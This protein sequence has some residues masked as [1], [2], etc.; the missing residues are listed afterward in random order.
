MSHDME[1]VIGNF[2]EFYGIREMPFALVPNTDYYVGLPDHN[3]CFNTLLFAVASGEGFIK[4]TGEVGTGKTLLCRR[5]LNSINHKRYQTAYFPNPRLNPV[6]LKRSLAKELGVENAQQLPEHQLLDV[7]Q[8][9][10]IEHAKNGKKVLFIM[11][12]AQAMPLESLEEL[13]LF[14]NLETEHHKLLQII[15]FGQPELDEILSKHEFRQLRQRI[16]FTGQLHKLKPPM[17]Q[18]YIH[19]RMSHAGYNGE[20]VFDKGCVKLL[21]RATEGV[22]RLLNIVC[23]KSLLIAYSEGK[24]KVLK[25]MVRQALADTE[26]VE[27]RRHW[28][29]G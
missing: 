2:H 26:G 16:S 15:L 14:S 5:L 18:Q 9:S 13:R 8:T 20:P 6:E 7:I 3:N 28:L 12:E 21:Y 17:V 22:P 23:N 29:W 1:Q 27:Y 10:L 24:H 19:H 4:I 11:D 25:R